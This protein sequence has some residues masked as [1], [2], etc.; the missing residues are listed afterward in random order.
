MKK[1]VSQYV[2]SF[3]RDQEGASGIEYALI[4]A[5]VAVVIAALVPDVS[6]SIRTIFESIRVALQD[7]TP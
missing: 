2:I 7:A 3:L 6:G 4:A 1:Q 5:M